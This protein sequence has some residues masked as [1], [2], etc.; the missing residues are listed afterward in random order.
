VVSFF[1]ISKK[2]PQIDKRKFFSNYGC[3]I[4]KSKIRIRLGVSYGVLVLI[5]ILIVGVTS[6]LQSKDSINNK[7]SNFSSQIMSQIGLN[8]SSEMDKASNFARSIVIEPDF[9]DYFQSKSSIESL[10]NYHI[11]NN[12]N[13]IISNK[14]A[15]KNDI[16]SLGIIS[17]E[18]KK[19]GSVSTQL[20]EDIKNNLFNLSNKAKGNFIWSLNKNSSGYSIYTSAQV[21]NIATGDNFGIVVEELNP[22]SFVKLFKNVNLGENSDIFVVDSKGTIILSEDENLIGSEYKNKSVINKI[23]DNE[24]NLNKSSDLIQQARPYFSTSDGK[25]MVSYSPLSGS[26]WYVVGIIPYSYL[27]SESNILRD[28]TIV[29]G[30]I[31]FIISMFVALIISKSIS[32]PLER[33]V[34]LMNTAKEGNLSVHITDESK[35]E[36]GEVIRAFNNMVEKINILICDVKVMAEDVSN[37]TKVIAEVSEH[38]YS[39]SEEIASTMSEIVIGASNQNVSVNEGMDCMN[40]LSNEINE[41]SRK[42]ESVYLVL[43][44]TKKLKEDTT[45]S[46]EILNN[47]SEETSKVAAKIIENINVLNLNIKDI[48]GIVELISEVAEQTNLLALN[49]AIEAARAGNAGKGF[50]VVA[51]EVRKLADKSKNSSVQINKIINNI[52]NETEIVVKEAAGFSNIIEEQEDAVGKADTAF[53]IIFEGVNDISNQLSEMVYSISKIADSK[54]NTELAMNNISSVSK[55]TVA[56]TEQVSAGAQ[57]QMKEIQRIYEYTEGLNRIVDNLNSAIDQFSNTN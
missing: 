11:V 26:D 27:N 20:P 23:Q 18:N 57:A 17:N 29:I 22:K 39:S 3:F 42:T 40:I 8:I 14:A 33:L 24:K 53:K 4:R 32:N 6:V 9:Q 31:S 34:L 49:A 35:D 54:D 46:V 41:V 16:I 25:N 2:D 45:I 36:I 44:E 52:Q 12:L 30:L 19:I 10:E 13:K 5:P 38:S 55:E 1:K 21:N 28:N 51:D 43:K 48:K 47:K 56:A 15:T 37:S 7:I 50:A